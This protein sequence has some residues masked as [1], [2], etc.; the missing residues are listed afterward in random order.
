MELERLIT[1]GPTL[2]VVLGQTELS[3]VELD[4]A[5]GRVAMLLRARGVAP[6]ER[7]AVMLD[8][9]AE[10]P[11]IYYGV[12]RAGGVVVPLGVTSSAPEVAARLV[13]T[14]ARIVFAWHECLDAAEAGAR[15]A[16]A[17]YVVVHPASFFAL[18]DEV[19]PSRDRVDREPADEAVILADGG[20]DVTL[21]H[22]DLANVTMP[23]TLEEGKPC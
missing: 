20:G 16:G 11:G 10:L 14:Q 18:L 22:A 21:T 9:V 7:I 13:E 8:R 2:V 3:Y 1:P 12:L 6:G 17:D 23:L 5:S 15:A 4:A 19:A